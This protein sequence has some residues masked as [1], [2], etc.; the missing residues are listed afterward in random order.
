MIFVTF[1]DRTLVCFQESI[2]KFID[3][4]S[5]LLLPYVYLDESRNNA[6]NPDFDYKVVSGKAAAAS[7]AQAKQ[8]SSEQHPVAVKQKPSTAPVSQVDS[9]EKLNRTKSPI[10]EAKDVVE[11]AASKSTSSNTGAIANKVDEKAAVDRA[12]FTANK[13]VKSGG[14]IMEPSSDSKFATLANGSD[15]R[16]LADFKTPT[17]YTAGKENLYKRTLL[18]LWA[19]CFSIF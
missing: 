17:F 10:T 9:V 14:E 16:K 7:E 18:D 2:F 1:S 5:Y 3:D 8:Q 6:A 13:S 4:P 11:V 15:R 19:P 12:F